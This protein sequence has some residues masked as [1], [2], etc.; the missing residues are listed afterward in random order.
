MT[1]LIIVESPNKIKSLSHILGSDWKVE[2]SVGHITELASD[3]EDNLGFDL[4]HQ[5]ITCR[6]QP[7]GERG[8]GVITRLKSLARVSEEIYLATDPDREGEGISWHL[9]EQVVGKKPYH[10]VTYTEITEKA[11]KA[12][13]ANPR[14]IDDALVAAQR[15]R[16]CLDKLVGFKCSGLVRNAGS[17]RSAG[18]VQSAAL[19]L[20][21]EL[22]RKI[23]GFKSTPYWALYSE[24]AEGFS[25][26]YLGA[27]AVAA[28]EAEDAPVDESADA[29]EAQAADTK[30]ILS[31]EE[32]TRIVGI[33]QANPH[34]VVDFT[35]KQ[36]QKPASPALTTSALQQAAG[37]KHG[38]TSDE[39]MKLA[40]QLFEGMKLPDGTHHG[41]ISYHRT[42][43]TTLSEEFCESV[44]GWLT[45]NH[46]QL[47]P[48]QATKH[49]NKAGTQGAHEAIR[50]V[51]VAFTPERMKDCLNADQL[52]LY[53]LIWQRAVAS[54]CA[55]A[56]FN[57]T[58][59]V[60]QAGSTF[61][62][63]R[64]AIM[65]APGF[66]TI[67][68]S[69]EGD[70]QLP[71]LKQG[72]SLGLIKAWHQAKKTTPPA[73]LSEPKLVQ[74]LERL[75][76]GR[77]STFANIIK[78]LKDR[79][80]VKVQGKAMIP[81][82][83]GMQTDEVLMKVF[84]TIIDSRFTA[85]MEADLDLIAEGQK[86]WEKYLAD[87]HFNFFLPALNSTGAKLVSESR[88]KSDTPCPKCAKPLSEMTLR[89]A[90]QSK[91]KHYLRC[92]EGCENMVL[93]WNDRQE[94]WLHPDD[95]PASTPAVPGKS[96]EFV[97]QHCGKPLEEFSYS[98]E[99]IEKKMLR[100][101]DPSAWK[102]EKHK[103]I[104]VYFMSSKGGWWNPTLQA[105][106][107]TSKVAGG[108]KPAARSATLSKG[109]SAVQGKSTGKSGAKASS[110][111]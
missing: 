22:E 109:K 79:E 10:R 39:T 52:K 97:C 107:S 108:D 80:Y 8:Q 9:L 57:R 78:T 54:Q 94:K 11:V 45:Q 16:Q 66:T 23:Q 72:Q 20:L 58:R 60:I 68:G 86:D 59:V 65:T 34:Q 29:A 70:T 101:S 25:A 31:V 5:G 85:K 75:G 3:G 64:G 55:P 81:T 90:T 17:G 67:T 28:T 100:C 50:P 93:F 62:E 104:G 38:F 21:C 30:R 47:V 73:R 33:A 12:A 19:H 51:D 99:G 7:R 2:A 49:K 36:S 4:S 26:S 77:P 74:T 105:E 27:E 53:T 6:Y 42:D 87:F 15:A 44:K 24:Y 76:I 69:L 37:V 95:K 84:P 13:I 82:P 91:V 102:D 98:K 56:Q 83:V 18:R 89:K 71:Q 92:M 106:A 1:K 43:S 88:K 32:A 48:A 35:S 103:A 111:R 14:K 61:W 96:T 63:A 40:Q 46:P 41:A 110:S